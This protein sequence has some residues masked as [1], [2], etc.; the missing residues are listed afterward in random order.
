[1]PKKLRKNDICLNCH[2][3]IGSANYCPE[4]GQM[5]SHKQIPITHFLQDIV[6][7]YLTFDSRFFKSFVPLLS[8]PGYLTNEYNTGKRNRYIFPLRLY[9]FATILFFF[10]I[11]VQKRVNGKTVEELEQE[12]T[13]ITVDSIKHTI[14]NLGYDLES[15]S[16]NDIAIELKSNFQINAKLH[17]EEERQTLDSLAHIIGRIDPAINMGD[18]GKIAK[19][20]DQYFRLSSKKANRDNDLDSLRHFLDRY[21]FLTE[22][23]KN[24]YVYQLDSLYRVRIRNINSSGS[25]NFV[26]NKDSLDE[27]LFKDFVDY[28]D[29]KGKYI[30]TRGQ[31][32]MDLILTE[33]INQVPKVM[34][35]ILPIF[36]LILKLLYIRKNILYINHLI[37]TLHLHTV[38]FIY[39]LIAILIQHWIATVGV[40][41]LIWFYM[42]FAFRN[43]YK[44]SIM[45]TALKLNSLLLIYIFPLF[46]GMLLM[47]IL[48]LLTV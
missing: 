38:I 40:I 16:L 14:K 32:G 37:F 3:T 36:A 9:I 5:N 18:R 42:F 4:C 20:T 47:I 48:A 2:A 8:K 26:T 23:S 34:F 12:A 21:N 19:Q 46:V 30:N 33:F 35:L 6:G 1:M 25:F 39:L 17:D 11:T 7:D 24:S 41:L 27:G 45:M 15:N 29:L 43:V 44:Q 10:V 31:E 13:P 22:Q 28:I